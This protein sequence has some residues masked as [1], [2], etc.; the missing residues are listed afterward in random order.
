MRMDASAAKLLDPLRWAVG[1][2]DRDQIR[3]AAWAVR[4]RHRVPSTSCMERCRSTDAALS[5]ERARRPR[6]TAPLPR[7][8]GRCH[9]IDAVKGRSSRHIG[10][11][12]DRRCGSTRDTGS[13]EVDVGALE[14]P[15]WASRGRTSASVVRR[16]CR[17]RCSCRRRVRRLARKRDRARLRPARRLGSTRKRGSRPRCDG[18]PSSRGSDRRFGDRRRRVLSLVQG[19]ARR[20]RGN[21]RE[22]SRVPRTVRAA[23]SLVAPACDGDRRVPGDAGHAGCHRGPRRSWMVSGAAGFRSRPLLVRRLSL[24]F[25]IA[26]CTSPKASI[27]SVEASRTST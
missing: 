10:L 20:V 17:G 22:A 5:V 12:R 3:A 13:G 16:R 19:T 14:A 7:P 27:G 4:S 25:T 24:T 23:R 2:G 9:A 15:R 11:R 21:L 26:G 18:C 1:N 6:R 8:W